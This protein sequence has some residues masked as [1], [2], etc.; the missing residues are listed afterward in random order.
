MKDPTLVGAAKYEA[1]YT[2]ICGLSGGER[3]KGLVFLM[4]SMWKIIDSPFYVLDEF[5]SMM[6]EQGRKY[7]HDKLV[8]YSN[9]NPDVQLLILT[10]LEIQNIEE[11]PNAD[12]IILKKKG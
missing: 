5:E 12:A 7:I 9:E 4:M 10:P 1:M 3:S 6:D 2:Y 11:Y 8:S